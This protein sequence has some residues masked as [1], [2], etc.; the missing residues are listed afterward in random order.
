M[1]S[2]SRM[3]GSLNDRIALKFDK[4]IN[5]S[6]GDVPVKRQ[7]DQ[8]IQN[9]NP[10][11]SRLCDILCDVLSDIETWPSTTSHKKYAQK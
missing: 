11:A 6:A 9:T 7:S 3:I 1:K 5:S 8:T 10:A 2:R 4:R